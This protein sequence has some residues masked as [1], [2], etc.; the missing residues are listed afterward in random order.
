M[1]RFAPHCT[2]QGP[3]LGSLLQN[4]HHNVTQSTGLLEDE[5]AGV[6]GCLM[7][8]RCNVRSGWFG[9]LRREA[10]LSGHY[11]AGEEEVMVPLDELALGGR[12]ANS[13]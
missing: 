5:G 11:L 12:G 8:L 6:G 4:T 3:N 2:W 10:M 1:I 13:G 7:R 9:G